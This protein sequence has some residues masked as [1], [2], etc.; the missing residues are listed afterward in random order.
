MGK[1]Q[2]S[3]KPMV[4]QALI[5]LFDEEGEAQEKEKS[6]VAVTESFPITY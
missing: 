1:I 5:R 6:P 3:N 4:E 2:T